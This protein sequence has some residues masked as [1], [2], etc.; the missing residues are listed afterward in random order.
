[1]KLLFVYPEP[2]AR[3]DGIRDYAARAVEQLRVEGEDAAL[4]HPD[5]GPR[6]GPTIVSAVG[7]RDHVAILVQYNPF[8]WG[9]W[10][11]APFLVVALALLRAARPRA[12]V[13]LVVHEGYVP[14][15]G[16]RSLL[17]GGW[18][19]MQLRILL[20]LAH[21]AVATTGR[22]TAELSRAWPRRRV[23]HLPVG[24]NLP[25]ERDSR[26]HGRELSGYTGQLVIASF[27]AGHETHLPT[28]VAGAAEAVARATDEP[29][30]LLQLGSNNPSPSDVLAVSRQVA[31]GYLEDAELA[32][33]L[34]TADIFLAPFSDGATTRRTTLMAALQHGIAT[35]TTVSDS[36][37]SVLRE[38]GTLAL[39]AVDDIDGFAAQ[40]VRV[41]T[42]R[43]AREQ[44]AHNGRALYEHCFSWPIVC[45]GLRSTIAAI[46]RESEQ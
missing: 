33:A 18:Q 46:S 9:R 26:A 14:I 27:S 34:A 4:L 10:G 15:R 37:E 25:D 6:L 28:H 40:A 45:A 24:S 23:D 39:A 19:R 29:V 2:A 8:A 42:D 16:W 12:R 32:R 3:V 20:S 36:T 30:V 1:M 43:S 31:P 7:R 21:G 38:D 35:V 11:F 17:M 5:R 13:L 22:L 41:A 44:H